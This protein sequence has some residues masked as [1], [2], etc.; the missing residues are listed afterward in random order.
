[1]LV[2][3]YLFYSC[4]FLESFANHGIQVLPP[5]SKVYYIIWIICIYYWFITLLCP[6]RIYLNV[7][8]L[9]MPKTL[10]SVV[11]PEST[12]RYFNRYIPICFVSTIILWVKD[13]YLCSASLFGASILITRLFTDHDFLLICFN[14]ARFICFRK[15]FL[16]PVICLAYV[17][18]WCC[19]CNAD[20]SSA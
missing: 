4:G 8:I 12:W 7:R 2:V 10:D 18:Y 13:F 19:Q 14:L 9:F 11:N 6:T 1:M 3:L 20:Y 16:T 17:I 15:I 5:F